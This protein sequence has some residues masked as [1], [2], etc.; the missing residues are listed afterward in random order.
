MT[1]NRRALHHL[2]TIVRPYHTIYFVIAC[3]VFA[4]I[5]A[6]ALRHNYQTM[7]DLR[8]AVF[9]ADSAQ[10]AQNG[11]V[12]QALQRLRSYVSQHMNTSLST[13]SSVYP[14]IQLK[15][16]YERLVQTEQ[17]RVNSVNSQVY[18]DAQHFCEAKYPQSVSG[19]PRVPCI[20]QYV[21]EHGTTAHAIQADLY[22]FD[23]ASPKWSPD[24]AGWSILF[25]VLFGILAIVRFAL[26]RVLRAI[27]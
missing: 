13:N 23:F 2:W 19:G 25:A 3:L 24:I 26:G 22:K 27:D 10:D 18:T 11:N 15:G 1:L 4:L 21:K 9:T 17:A 7:V 20:E 12:E 16:T 6:F 8:Q 14:P 5:A